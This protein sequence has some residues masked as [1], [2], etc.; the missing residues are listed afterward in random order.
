MDFLFCG[1]AMAARSETSKLMKNNKLHFE[2]ILKKITPYESAV[3]ELL[4]E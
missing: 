4:F 1:C 2:K 3:E